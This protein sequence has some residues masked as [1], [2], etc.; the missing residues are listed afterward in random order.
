MDK[1]LSLFCVFFGC[2]IACCAWATAAPL[3]ASVHSN[4]RLEAAMAQIK[5]YY[6]D[7]PK[8]EKMLSDAINGMLSGLD[9][10]SSYLD[11]EALKE[12]ATHTS[13]EFSGLGL[14]ITTDQGLIK[15]IAPIDGSPA[16]RAGIKAGDYILAIDNQPL[17]HMP[18]NDAIKMIRGKKGT[19]VSLSV[20][21]KK[22]Q[23][24]RRVTFLRSVVHIE[25]VKSRL[26]ENGFGYI[27][28]THFQEDTGEKVIQ[29]LNTLVKTN[30]APLQGLILDLRNNPGGLLDSAVTVTDIFLDSHKMGYNKKIV[31]TQGR[32]K[33][34]NITAYATKDD[35][36][37]G[38][39]L[40]ILINEGS[41]SASEV[42]AGALQ[43]HKRAVIVGQQS[44]GKGSVQTI[45]PLDD[46]SALKLTTALYYTPSGRSIQA[47]GIHPDILVDQLELKEEKEDAIFFLKIHE[48]T[49]NNHIQN[50]ASLATKE[51]QRIV[52]S[53]KLKALAR[54]DYQ[55]YEALQILKGLYAQKQSAVI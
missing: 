9:P 23:K 48:A 18:L 5:K 51:S 25:N 20:F 39:P 34:D 13:G 29:A 15:I 4:P 8:N 17:T 28:I 54:D 19:S 41:A 27:R 40:V 14:E 7:S 53:G 12:L 30:K 50:N 45:L 6:I 35:F 43:D 33:D 46:T 3:T 38:A 44:F 49:L 36:L 16:D 47:Q 10:H 42:V 11:E 1:S 32:N 22:D 24:P 55:L 31:Y 52:K 21:N 37:F 2:L 26:L